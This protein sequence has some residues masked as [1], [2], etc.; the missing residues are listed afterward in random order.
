MIIDIITAVPDLFD[1]PLSASIVKRAIDKGF[2]EINLHN[3]RD[4]STNKHKQIDDYQFGGGAGMVL[5]IEPIAKCID[6]LLA[7][8]KYDEIIYVTPDGKTYDQKEANKLS[9][10][11]N[12]LII[13]GHYKGID[14]RI[15]DLYVTKEISIG[16][17]V[18]S[19][20]EM[21]A[22]IIADSIVRLIPGVLGDESSALSDSFQD[23][24]LAPPV[25]TRPAEFR[26]LKVPEIL[27]SGDH[28]KIDD[29]RLQEAIRITKNKRPDL[30]EK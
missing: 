23:D 24:L 16:D 2:V 11:E 18:L 5:M 6:S 26:G 1:G 13:A 17:F 27:L 21:P 19:G 25:F 7:K 22:A 4:Y 29:W 15:R 12:I 3:I 28:K 10:H 30:L 14:Q 8:R 20:G 9:L